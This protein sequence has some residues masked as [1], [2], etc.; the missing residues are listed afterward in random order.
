MWT[1]FSHFMQG[2]FNMVTDADGNPVTVC[3]Y[4]LTHLYSLT[5]VCAFSFQSSMLNFD[6]FKK[7][8]VE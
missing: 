8:T 2:L 5:T 7:N 6:I 1:Q 3:L 4:E